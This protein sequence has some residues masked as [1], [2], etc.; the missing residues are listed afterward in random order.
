MSLDREIER[1][2]AVEPSPE[3][4]AR[5]RQRIA[6]EPQPGPSWFSWRLAVA[7]T[8]LVTVGAAF[9]LWSTVPAPTPGKTMKPAVAPASTPVPASTD[10]AGA[11]SVDHT[12]SRPTRGRPITAANQF[13]SSAVLIQRDEARA[14]DL[15]LTRVREGTLPDM[16]TVLADVDATGPKWIEIPAVKIDPIASGEGE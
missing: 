7:A 11:A 14:M 15:L 4:V 16:T 10:A 3:F 6:L 8:S 2:L 9:A 12:V 1:L 13:A 5:V